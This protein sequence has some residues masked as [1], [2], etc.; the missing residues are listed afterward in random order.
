MISVAILAQAFEKKENKFDTSDWTGSRSAMPLQAERDAK[1][2]QERK[3]AQARAAANQKNVPPP[4]GLSNKPK[5]QSEPLRD[6]T[7]QHLKGD[8][9]DATRDQSQVTFLLGTC[10]AKVRESRRS[11]SLG[12]LRHRNQTLIFVWTSLSQ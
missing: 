10:V 8:V 7:P 4:P 9:D 3:A 2:E 5:G 1:E 12:H 6:I 11:L